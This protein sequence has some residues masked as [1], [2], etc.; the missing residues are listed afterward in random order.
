MRIHTIVGLTLPAIVAVHA[1][2]RFRGLIGLGYLGMI[3]VSLSGIVGRYLYGR[4]PRTRAGVELSRDE[5]AGRRRALVTEIAATLRQDPNEV[6]AILSGGEAAGA[7]DGIGATFRRLM[8]DDW[9]RWR[10]VRD[11]RQRWRADRSANLSA[12][13]SQSIDRAVRL[14]REEIRLRQQLD[15]LS[16]TQ[17]VFR[18]WHVAHR[19]VSITALFAIAIHVGVAIAMGQ[20]WFR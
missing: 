3:V 16:A 1:G 18:F 5:I 9:R 14:A 11:L 12:A 6:A 13:Q 15:M 20:T 10:S 7:T 8:V 19:P 4:I 17:R 2:W